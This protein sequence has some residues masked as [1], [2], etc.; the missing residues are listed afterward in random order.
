MTKLDKLHEYDCVLIDLMMRKPAD[1]DVSEDEETGEALYKLIR[2][3]HPFLPI[4]IV[5]GKDDSTI[6]CDFG[7]PNTKV[8]YKPLDSKIDDLIEAIQNVQ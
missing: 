5:T 1:L 2:K 4:V 3:R 8:I 6:T 7:G